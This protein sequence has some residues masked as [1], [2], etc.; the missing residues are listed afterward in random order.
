[1]ILLVKEVPISHHKY[2]WY[3]T[4]KAYCFTMVDGT[5]MLCKHAIFNPLPVEP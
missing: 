1:M 4:T 2:T 5:W 3:K